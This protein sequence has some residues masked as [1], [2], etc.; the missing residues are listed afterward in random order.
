MP[1]AC[2]YNMAA[3][4]DDG[5]CIFIGDPCD[6]GNLESTGDVYNSACECEGLVTVDETITSSA[7]YPNPAKDFIQCLIR[8]NV[9][10]RI[11]IY[12][13]CGVLVL[14]EIKTNR[15]SVAMLANGL[16]TIKMTLGNDTIIRRL[17]I[18]K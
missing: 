11:E 7:L 12:D 8:N 3:T 1:D 18:I 6:D 17:E 14:T 5:S 10:D 15:V 16:Y 2:N 9:P 4:A 13:M